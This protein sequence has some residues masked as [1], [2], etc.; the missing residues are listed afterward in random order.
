M[1]INFLELLLIK[2]LRFDKH[3]LK[4]YSK[5]NQKLSAFSRMAKLPSF[6]KTKTLSEVFWESHFN[7]WPIVWLFHS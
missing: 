5:A 6:I 1:M 4:L 2:N 7:Y 3:V